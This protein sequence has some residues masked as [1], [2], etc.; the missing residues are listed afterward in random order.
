M[1]VRFIGS[2][3]SRGIPSPTS[4]RR[5]RRRRRPT[6][7]TPSPKPT[8]SFTS[9]LPTRCEKT[10]KNKTESSF[11]VTQKVDLVLAVPTRGTVRAE[12]AAMLAGLA[13]PIN[14]TQMLRVIPGRS[15]EEARNVAV[16]DATEH[17]AHYLLFVDDDVLIPNQGL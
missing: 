17:G 4:L 7:N 8:A 10:S 13:M 2:A 6:R 15:V 9:G 14:M 1:C 5:W 12:W 16:Q 11:P 3:V